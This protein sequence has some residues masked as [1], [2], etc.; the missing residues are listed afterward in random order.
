LQ[1]LYRT[2][3]QAC[4]KVAQDRS[5]Y[6]SLFSLHMRGVAPTKT[7]LR[8]QV[9]A[10]A[11]VFVAFAMAQRE[12]ATLAAEAQRAILR[13]ATPLFV[14]YILARYGSKQIK[15][16]MVKCQ[17]ISL[18]SSDTVTQ[19]T[20]P[21]NCEYALESEKLRSKLIFPVNCS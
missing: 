4:D 13:R 8:R 19:L 11:E 6:E 20:L 14:Q 12:V 7:Q 1:N 17:R 18:E 16:F 21:K 10:V 2:W 5:F 9:V 3:W 15:S